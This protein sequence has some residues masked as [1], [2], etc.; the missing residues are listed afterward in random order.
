[1]LI[2]QMSSVFAGKS[3]QKLDPTQLT[4]DHMR[5]S[6]PGICSAHHGSHRFAT[7]FYSSH[8]LNPQSM[9]PWRM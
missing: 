7:F 2:K 3:E 5:C 8:K 9:C 6:C 1:M 4:F